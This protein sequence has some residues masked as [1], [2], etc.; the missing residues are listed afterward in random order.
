MRFRLSQHKRDLKLMETLIRKFGTGTI[1]KYTHTL[2][3]SVVISNFADITNIIIPFFKQNSLIG[4]KQK[5]YQDWI[6]VHKLIT[7]GSYEG[8]NLIREIKA[9][10]NKGRI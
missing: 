4:V 3:V 10:M 6:K 9:G 5:H 7:E 1:Y 2:A 8:L